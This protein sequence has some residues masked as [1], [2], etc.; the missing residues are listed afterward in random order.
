MVSFV[1]YLNLVEGG[2][3]EE[4]L[5]SFV[6]QGFSPRI[7]GGI[8]AFIGQAAYQGSLQGRT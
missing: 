3:E 5:K 2:I 6:H 1:F 8:D 4:Q 7:I